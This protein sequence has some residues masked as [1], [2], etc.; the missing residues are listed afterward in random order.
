MMRLAAT[1]MMTGL[2]AFGATTVSYAH[3]HVFA[4]AKLEVTVTNNGTIEALRHVWRFDELFTATVMLEFDNNA[5][6]VM[7]DAET[8]ALTAV[9]T[10]SI[11]DFNYFLD[12]SVGSKSYSFQ[13]V[14]DMRALF[15]DGQMIILFTAKPDGTVTLADKPHVSVYDPTFYT[16]IEFYEDDAMALIDAPAGCSHE[17]VIP[18]I[19]AILAESQNTLT[20]DFFNDPAG[21][22]YSRMFATRMEISCES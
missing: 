3:P 14:D 17:M 19:D 11:A 20:E 7:D 4:E 5:D 16:S 15:D 6:G 22:D 9:I 2:I 21:N 13:Q 1:A 18:D 8:D 10:E 12:L